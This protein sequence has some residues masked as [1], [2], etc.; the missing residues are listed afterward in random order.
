[1]LVGV[2]SPPVIPRILHQVWL[3]GAPPDSVPDWMATWR[4]HHPAWEYRLWTDGNLPALEN[5]DLFD[6]APNPA[7]RA[8]LLRYELLH[9]FGGLYV[10]ADF[11]CFRSLDPRLR[12]GELIVASEHGV[13]TNSFMGAVPG[14]HI[15]RALIER[16]AQRL[17]SSGFGVAPTRTTGPYLVDSLFGEMELAFDPQVTVLPSDFLFPPRTRVKELVDQ[18]AAKLYARH[19]ELASWRTPTLVDRLHGTLKLGTRL[20]RFLDLSHP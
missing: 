8:D 13:L 16:S 9:R 3:G 20:R 4:R 2:W 17:R 7:Q 19:H 11:E 5:Q 1:V 18:G 15:L 10:D 6:E 14:H 12:H